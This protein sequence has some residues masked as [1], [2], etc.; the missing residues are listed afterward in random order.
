MFGTGVAQ[1]IGK[2]KVS[3]LLGIV[4]RPFIGQNATNI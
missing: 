2:Q 4:T 3:S 1:E